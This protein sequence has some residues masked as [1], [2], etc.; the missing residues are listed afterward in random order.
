M[1]RGMAAD[2]YEDVQPILAQIDQAILDGGDIAAYTVN[3]RYTQLRSL[4][5]LIMARKYFRA[6]AAKATGLRRTRVRFSQ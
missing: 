4:N 2:E 6:E 3:G 5:E 1:L